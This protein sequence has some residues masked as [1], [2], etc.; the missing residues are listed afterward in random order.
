MYRAAEALSHQMKD[1]WKEGQR[2][3][4]RG[5][6]QQIAQFLAQNSLHK[7]MSK[8]RTTGR[9]E[10]WKAVCTCTSGRLWRWGSWKCLNFG[11]IGKIN[12]KKIKLVLVQLLFYHCNENRTVI[13]RLAAVIATLSIPSKTENCINENVK[14]VMRIWHSRRSY[15]SKISS[16]LRNDWRQA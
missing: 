2:S 10:P 16:A 6:K 7:Q 8:P 15:G 3:K 4:I 1:Q 13:I 5:G 9:E 14:I 11:Q 12:Y